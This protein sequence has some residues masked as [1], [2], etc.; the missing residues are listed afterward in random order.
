MKYIKNLI[1]KYAVFKGRANRREFWICSVVLA[2]IY[3]ALGLFF[4]VV[5]KIFSFMSKQ[6]GLAQRSFEGFSS[7]VQVIGSFVIFFI[8][9]LPF[10]ALTAR[11]LHDV[12]IPTPFL[13]VCV[14]TGFVAAFFDYYYL[15]FIVVAI[16]A[17]LMA[18]P[19]AK[20]HNEF[21]LPSKF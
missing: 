20:G 13:W 15:A 12:N 14:F 1:S 8:C 19:S 5:T 7:L 4:S 11:R 16:V 9:V 10:F 21:G 6:E 2:V 18:W 17:V 3:L